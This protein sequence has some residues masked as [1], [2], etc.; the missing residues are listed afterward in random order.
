MID[1]VDRATQVENNFKAFQAKLADLLPAYAGK[2]AV[3]H[4][5]N[6]VDVFDSFA[7]AIK[8][9]QEKFGNAN[10]FSV[11]EITARAQS[12]GFYAHAAGDIR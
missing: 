11:Q 8:F 3:L 4:D 6:V 5:G 9:G 12:L 2:I 10:E 7:D 1:A